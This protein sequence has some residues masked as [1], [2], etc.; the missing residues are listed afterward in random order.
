MSGRIKIRVRSGYIEKAGSIG[1][2]L[3]SAI[4]IDSDFLKL[5]LK[6]ITIF[7]QDYLAL[8]A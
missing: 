6:K 5:D 8:Q 2:S 3:W 7:H 4:Y 1:V